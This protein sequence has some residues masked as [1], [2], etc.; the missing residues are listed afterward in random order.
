MT[1]PDNANGNGE[2]RSGLRIEPGGRREYTLTLQEVAAAL[3]TD[4]RKVKMLIREGHLR[5]IRISP[6]VVRV[7]ERALGEFLDPPRHEK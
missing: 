6:K 2:R 7:T 5:A 1:N 4:V 3:K